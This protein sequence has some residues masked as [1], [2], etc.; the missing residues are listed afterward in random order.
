MQTDYEY[1]L[2]NSLTNVRQNFLNDQLKE[3]LLHSLKSTVKD[4]SKLG[5]LTW[6]LHGG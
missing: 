3:R 4:R 2:G 5:W 6:V 1:L